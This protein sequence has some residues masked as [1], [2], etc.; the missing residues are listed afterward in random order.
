MASNGAAARADSGSG[1]WG[2][3]EEGISLASPAS[4]EQGWDWRAGEQGPA[5]G[6]SE[7]EEEEVH[8]IALHVAGFCCD[9]S[10]LDHDWRVLLRT[11]LGP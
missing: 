8:R 6:E 9:P 2:A 5:P 10:A 4:R 11:P 1:L 7:E 3:A